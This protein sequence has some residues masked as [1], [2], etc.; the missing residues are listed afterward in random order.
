MTKTKHLALYGMLT[1]LALVLGYVEAMIPALFAVPGMKLGLTNLVVLVAL[2]RMDTKSAVCINGIRIV[3]T[4][5]LFGTAVSFL[6]SLARPCGAGR[7]SAVRRRNDCTQ[8]DRKIPAGYR[9]YFGR[10]AA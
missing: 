3:L 5:I 9:Q 10:R 4:S 1:A 8:T 2:Y 6:Y 7:R